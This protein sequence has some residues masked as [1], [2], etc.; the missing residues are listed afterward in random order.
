MNGYSV[1]TIGF[2]LDYLNCLFD[3]IGRGAVGSVEAGG[4]GIIVDEVL[5]LA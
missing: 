3:R 4:M 5:I 1:P 2:F